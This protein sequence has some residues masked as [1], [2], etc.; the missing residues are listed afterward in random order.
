MGFVT[1]LILMLLMREMMNLYVEYANLGRKR[2]TLV[3]KS[4]FLLSLM[5]HNLGLKDMSAHSF[6]GDH[7]AVLFT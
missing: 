3:V 1:L 5:Y 7:A 4:A 6:P 2:P